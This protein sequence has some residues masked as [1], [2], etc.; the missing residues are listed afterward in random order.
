MDSSILGSPMNMSLSNRGIPMMFFKFAS[1][2]CI[3]AASLVAGLPALSWAD[4]VSDFYSSHTIKLI[5]AS[6]PGGGYDTYARLL[7]PYLQ[8]HLPGRPNIII[9]HVPGA[10]G[11][12][13]ANML[14]NL[15]PKDGSVIAGVLRET[16][17]AP[18]LG[19]ANADFKPSEFGW[20]GS[21]NSEEAIC[22]AWH[23]A[24][25]KT[26]NDLYTTELI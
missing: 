1:T 2:C 8:K 6:G 17:V 20:I 4:T 5:V 19:M 13:A 14:H 11:L 22:G 16:I 21:L 25:V 24:K 18:I 9:Q 12:Q 7:S 15:V 26:L 23:T 10:G 3:G